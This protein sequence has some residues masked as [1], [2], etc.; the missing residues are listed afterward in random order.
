MAESSKPEGPVLR[1]SAQWCELARTMLEKIPECRDCDCGQVECCTK[2]LRTVAEKGL[3]KGD[4][5]VAGVFALLL[6]RH[7]ACSDVGFLVAADALIKSE[8]GAVLRPIA[9][10]VRANLPAPTI[11]TG[12][13]NVPHHL[14]F[15]A[16]A[17]AMLNTLDATR[18]D[19]S[20]DPCRTLLDVVRSLLAVDLDDLALVM[21]LIYGAGA[22][23]LPYLI[24]VLANL[25]ANP[26]FLS[27]AVDT[28]TNPERN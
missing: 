28:I 24:N 8:L 20:S 19:S 1:T 18:L 26:E 2:I 22:S 3:A 10:R 9:D 23:T 11:T 25:G 15:A 14:Q 21:L 4:G 13:P 5:G 12:T 6:F 17:R 27:A 16:I 7:R